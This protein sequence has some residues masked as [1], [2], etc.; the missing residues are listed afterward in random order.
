[1]HDLDGRVV[2]RH[3]VLDHDLANR[4]GSRG[5]QRRARLEDRHEKVQI[6]GARE[7]DYPFDTRFSDIGRRD[8]HL[9]PG[10]GIAQRDVDGTGCPLVDEQ[11]GATAPAGAGDEHDLAQMEVG[12]GER[13]PL[14]EHRVHVEIL[15]P[16]DSHVVDGNL[17]TD[18][19]LLRVGFWRPVGGGFW[20]HLGNDFQCHL[21]NRFRCG[22]GNDLRY[23][24][25]LR[26]RVDALATGTS[27]QATHGNRGPK[28][29]VPAHVHLHR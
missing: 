3:L 5:E 7:V 20:C 17:D 8:A 27:G 1:M 23:R 19:V 12:S 14:V 22:V 10:T 2:D 21:G 15:T 6:Q 18:P 4:G 16:G 9:V 13:R 11:L 24:F 25:D 29:T 28:R 26:V